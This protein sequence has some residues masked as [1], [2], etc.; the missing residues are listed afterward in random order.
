ARRLRGRVGSRPLRVRLRHG[1]PRTGPQPAGHPRAQ[2][3]EP[4]HRPPS[5]R[6]LPE[7]RSM[8]AIDLAVIGGTGIYRLAELNQAQAR[9]IDTPWGA[10]SGPLRVG[11]LGQA[12]VAFLA[13]HG[14]G[15]ALPPHRVNYRANLHALHQAGPR[16]VLALN[17]VGGIT[18]AYGPRVPACPD[19]LIGYTWGRAGTCCDGGGEPPRVDLGHP[20]S[21]RLRAALLRA[22]AAAG[23]AGVAGGCEGATQGRRLQT[24]AAPTRMGRD[25]GALVGMTGMPEAGRAREL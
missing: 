9:H 8:S 12:T 18:E 1:L 23:V 16:R 11:R 25:G 14:E 10:P 2:G 22:A 3:L 7:P 24:S 20:D 5:P 21:P 17:T 19:Q 15:H 4:A 6:P 13:R